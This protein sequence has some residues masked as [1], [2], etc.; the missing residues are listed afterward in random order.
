MSA[1]LEEAWDT[2]SAITIAVNVQTAPS[3]HD[4]PEVMTELPT[5]VQETIR[6]II[7]KYVHEDWEE[8]A[9]D[10]STYLLVD[11]IERM[12][13]AGV[14]GIISNRPRATMARIAQ[15]T[16]ASKDGIQQ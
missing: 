15:S 5:P 4:A 16:Y 10:G 9:E 1:F 12:L 13:R 7:R 8:I 2:C 6:G 3:E 11:G 14:D